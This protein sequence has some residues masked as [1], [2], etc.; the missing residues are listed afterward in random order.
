MSVMMLKVLV[1]ITSPPSRLLFLALHK[2]TAFSQEHF[3]HKNKVT[4]WS[5]VFCRFGHFWEPPRHTCHSQ[6][7]C[8][9]KALQFANEFIHI[10]NWYKITIICLLQIPMAIVICLSPIHMA[11]PEK[12]DPGPKV[13]AK[14]PRSLI[15][16]FE[17]GEE[18]RTKNEKPKS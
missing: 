4:L 8:L 17:Q 16:I 2:N 5:I 10:T 6:W 9:S 18:N 14:W 3:I 12:S 13:V 11:T 1:T 7:L 15:L